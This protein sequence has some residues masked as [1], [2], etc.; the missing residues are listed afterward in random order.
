MN[1]FNL[2][3]QR[4]SMI[5]NPHTPEPRPVHIPEPGPDNVPEPNPAD[6]LEPEPSKNPEKVVI[7]HSR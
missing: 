5:I 3:M 6:P 7:L 4:T 1:T 2:D